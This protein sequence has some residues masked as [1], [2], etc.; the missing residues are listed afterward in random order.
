V[1]NNR[2]TIHSIIR[3]KKLV[4]ISHTAHQTHPVHGLVGWGPTVREINFLADYWDE[5]VHVACLEPVIPAGSSL[6]YSSSKI[7]LVPIP[8][9]GGAHWWQKFDIITKAPKVLFAVHNAIKDATEVQLRLPMSMGVFLLPYFKLLAKRTFKLWVKY[10]TNWG[11]P[12]QSASY[13]WQQRQL[14]NNW[15]NCPVTIN[16][17][18]PNQPE[19][20]KTF[21]NPCLTTA[22]YE[23]GAAVTA[24]KTLGP[25]YTVIFIGRVDTAKGVDMIMDSMYNWPK[26]KI[27]R[28]HIVGE[29]PLLES[30]KNRIDSLRI[31]L[32]SHGFITQEA[33]F[34]LLA[35]SH[36][37][38]LPSRS[39]GFPKVVAESLNFGCLPIV[40]AVGSIP[41]YIHDG[42]NGF[43]M[44]GLNHESLS[45]AFHAATHVLLKKHENMVDDG[46]L[47]A[48]QFTFDAYLERL[49]QKI[50]GVS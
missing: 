24:N 8:T 12:S 39:E 2:A 45:R 7:S 5:I 36:F 27:S 3:L 50:L 22:Q 13:R 40:S 1:E 16:G 32:V 19:H 48:E 44:L 23:A 28:F 18:W 20:C 41:H 11:Q 33:I 25:P 31:P 4:I 10:A 6:P 38:V 35:E 37:L 15:L 34:Q 46:R 17:F 43:L 29:G 9:F 49:Q 14:Y 21:E 26:D 42:L 47:L 30:L